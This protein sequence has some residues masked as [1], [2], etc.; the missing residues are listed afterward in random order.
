M[1]RNRATDKR[2]LSYH[3][4][5]DCDLRVVPNTQTNSLRYL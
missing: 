1:L 4:L 3:N 2:S 5:L